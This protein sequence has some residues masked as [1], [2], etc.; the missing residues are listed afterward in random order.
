MSTRSLIEWTWRTWNPIVG[1]SMV[2]PGCALCYALL[3]SL[4]LAG[5][6][7][8]QENPGRKSHYLHV[9]NDKGGWNG[10]VRPVEEALEDPL[11]WRRPST[12][13]VNS[14]SD[15]FHE[16]LDASYI[17]RVFDVMRRAHWHQFQIL[18]KR[19]ERLRD[20][21]S[22]LQWMPNIW[23]GVSVELATYR[24]R[25]DHLR[26]TPAKV[27]FLSLEPLLG[28]LGTLDLRGIDWVIVGGESGAGCRPME[29]KWVTDIQRQCL[30]AKVPFFFKQWG[31]IQ[32]NP[33]PS[34]PT[35][36]VNSGTSKGGR[37]LNGEIWDE[38]PAVQNISV[39]DRVA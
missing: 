19:S 27:K 37:T 30:S 29:E 34:D 23:Q 8:V 36:K 38:M 9:I 31:H 21:S 25:I 10:H 22:S 15:L 16:N 26:A 6:A 11:H 12:V 20:L 13:F 33:D 1:C 17:Q 14:M 24:Y 3:M 5:M 35:A 28:P 32:N 18:T 39:C 7:R 2:S 4:R